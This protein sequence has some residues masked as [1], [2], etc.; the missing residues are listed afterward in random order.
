V[1]PTIQSAALED[2]GLLLARLSVLV[3]KY[4]TY[5][6]CSARSAFSSAKSAGTS[7]SPAVAA[8]AHNSR[9]RSSRG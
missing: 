1:R 3:A 9:I 2:E 7:E 6:E 4:R 5:S 8:F